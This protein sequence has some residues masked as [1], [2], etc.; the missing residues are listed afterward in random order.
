MVHSTCTTEAQMVRRRRQHRVTWFVHVARFCES[1]LYITLP[2]DGMFQIEGLEGTQ[3]VPRN[4]RNACI[5]GNIS[6]LLL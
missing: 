4:G 6:I 2:I 1:K 5:Y 3:A